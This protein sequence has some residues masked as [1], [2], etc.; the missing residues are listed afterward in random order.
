MKQLGTHQCK[1]LTWE[2]RLFC[3]KTFPL[4]VERNILYAE[5]FPLCV[6]FLSPDLIISKNRFQIFLGF[7]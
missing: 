3:A 6:G 2:Y 5:T 4:C 7:H 1:N